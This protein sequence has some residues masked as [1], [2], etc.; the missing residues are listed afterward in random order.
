MVSKVG[1][2]KIS[3]KDAQEIFVVPK[4]YF[5][6]LKKSKKTSVSDLRSSGLLRSVE[7]CN[8][9]HSFWPVKQLAELANGPNGRGKVARGECSFAWNF[10]MARSTILMEAQKRTRP[11]MTMPLH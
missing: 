3:W 11:N 1:S 6:G 9:V 2:R 10:S 4:C 5:K 8:E 7:W